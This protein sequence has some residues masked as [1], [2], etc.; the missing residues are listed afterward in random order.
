MK[1]IIESAAAIAVI[2]AGLLYQGKIDD[3]PSA[4]RKAERPVE[5]FRIV[6]VRV[7]LFRAES[8]P[9]IGV[10]LK[11]S[12]IDRI[13][14]KANNIWHA[15]GIH[16]WVESIVEEEPARIDDPHISSLRSVDEL[17]PLVRR[18]HFSAETFFCLLL[19]PIFLLGAG[20]YLLTKALF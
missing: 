10:T 9:A 19:L 2:A 14:R 7:H 16:L 1:R 17:L 13:F 18:E 20:I 3:P 12:D 6:P 5:E 8:A 11:P 15:A 4:Q